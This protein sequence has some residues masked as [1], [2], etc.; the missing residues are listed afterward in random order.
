MKVY[1]FRK[2]IYSSSKLKKK[3]HKPSNQQ[4]SPLC[5][6]VVSKLRNA[7]LLLGEGAADSARGD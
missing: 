6:A 1:T 5:W 4:N 2:V 3:Q 7:I